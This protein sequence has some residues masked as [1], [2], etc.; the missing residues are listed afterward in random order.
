MSRAW[1][2]PLLPVAAALAAACSAG[3]MPATEDRAPPDAVP[4][5]GFIVSLNPQVHYPSSF[6]EETGLRSILGT[7]DLGVGRHRVSFVL[8]HPQGLLRFPTVRVE[9]YHLP[10]GP[11]GPREGPLESGSAQFFE[12]PLGTRG[13]YVAELSFDRAG[14][15]EIEVSFPNAE[16]GRT[17]TR[18]QFEV[19]EQTSAPAV[20]DPAPRSQNATIDDVSAIE[21]LTTGSDPD[22]EL[23]RLSVADAVAA[24]RPFVVVFASP[25]FCTNALCG[26]QVD[27]V[28]V[29][30]ERYAGRADFIHIDVYAN[31][32]EIQGDL[33][34]A[35]RNPIL[36]EWGITTDEWTF[37]VDRSGRIAARFQSFAPEEE[38]EQALLTVLN[39]PDAPAEPEA[40]P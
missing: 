22:P 6:D 1:L 10:D 29:L 15:W 25:A 8:T 21:E 7:P 28:S 38:L 35:V 19:R 14:T 26:P 39:A 36:D 40:R 27:V 2:L 9:S 31:P 20:G 17:A 3:V 34:S 13:I 23:Y 30:R 12:F 16:G 37:V 32:H 24:G 11:A 4:G 33:A 5:T 18:L